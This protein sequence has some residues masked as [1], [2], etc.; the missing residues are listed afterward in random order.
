[1]TESFFIQRKWFRVRVLAKNVK[2]ECG[3]LARFFFSFWTSVCH[4]NP[5][6]AIGAEWV[7]TFDVETPKEANPGL[8]SDAFA[9]EEDTLM[10]ELNLLKAPQRHSLLLE[11]VGV[12]APL[13]GETVSSWDF[14]PSRCSPSVLAHFTLP[15]W[16]P[17][18]VSRSPHWSWWWRISAD[19]VAHSHCR[20]Y[21]GLSMPGPVLCH[22]RSLLK[23]Y[24]C[25]L[26]SPVCV[27][28]R[29]LR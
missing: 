1:M 6:D 27:C 10:R 15:V 13:S 12:A 23:I 28:A 14:P 18:V 29:A 2:T 19:K 9:S 20:G 21:Q 11:K 7:V 17:K 4:G 5:R 3:R 24:G 8:C 22:H 16:K 26:S 25:Y